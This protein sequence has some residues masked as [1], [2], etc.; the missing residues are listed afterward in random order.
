MIRFTEVTE[1]Q[2][3]ALARRLAPTCAAGDIICLSGELGVGKTSFARGLL[4]G[5]GWSDSAEVASPTYNLVLEYLPPQVR[6]PVAHVDLYRLDDAD[7]VRSLG[8]EDMMDD[9]LL[10]IEWPERWGAELPADHLQIDLSGSG[11]VRSILLSGSAPWQSRMARLR[12][13]L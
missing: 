11:A 7:A 4:H 9:H 8:L 2:M 13:Q 1:A 12:E 3:T 6:L 5:L 10:I